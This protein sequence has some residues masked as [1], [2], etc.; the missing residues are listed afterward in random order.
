MHELSVC[1]GLI[2]QVTRIVEE[3]EATAVERIVVQIGPL[4]G[5]EAPLLE[6][7]YSLARA[8]TVAEGAE[9]VTESMPV[10]VACQSCGAE[11]DAQANRLVCGACG[12]YRTRLVS[13]DELIL[14]S[15][16]LVKGPIH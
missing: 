10:R 6:Q 16:E 14:A 9:L 1:Q 3:N 5:V 13:G 15:V 12:D 2:S 8:G 4:S 7:A 11:T